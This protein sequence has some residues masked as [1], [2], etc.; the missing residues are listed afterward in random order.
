MTAPAQSPP[1]A[2]SQSPGW[3]E[4][5]AGRLVSCLASG[6]DPDETVRQILR[7]IRDETGLP[8]GDVAATRTGARPEEVPAE[9]QAQPRSDAAL[10]E[11]IIRDTTERAQAEAALRLSQE[12]LRRA[13]TLAHIGNWEWTLPTGELHWEE[14][15]HRIFGLAPDVKPSVETFLAAVHPEDRAFVEQSIQAALRGRPYDLDM[16]ILRPDGVERVVHAFA[17]VQRDADGQPVRMFGTVQDITDRRRAEEEG[18]KLQAE[19]FQAQKME[20]IGTL[21]GGI[22]HDFNNLL[23]GIMS[24][25]SLLELDLGEGSGFHQDLEEIKAQVKRGA[26]LTRQ[27][28]GFARGGR[29]DATPQDLNGILERM[30]GMFGR[31]RK[32]LTIRVECSPGI[33]A[34]MADPTQIE[35]TLLNLFLN[36]GQ[37][38]PDGGDLR[39]RTECVVLPAAETRA[40]GTEPGRF[41]KLSV[42]DT[43]VGMDAD[44]RA[45]I[46]DP[47]FT[48]R[49]PGRGTGLGLASVYGILRDHKGFVTVDS[50]PGQGSTFAVFLPA[51]DSPAV[52]PPTVSVAP[53]R[54]GETILVVD[55]EEQIVRTSSRLLQALGHHVLTA[56]SGR[57]ALEVFKQNQ[58]VVAL[59]ILDMIMPGLSGRQTM[60]AMREL[61]PDVKVLLSSGYHVDGQAAEIL[62][63]G[64]Q[65]FLAKPFDLATLS[66]KLRE[67]L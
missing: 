61:A 40:Y 15:N 60:A 46:F 55:D 38:M 64:C 49:Q 33:P 31:T 16:R 19:L 39:L 47:F 1:E 42:T 11:S 22:A 24:G 56:R 59:V 7:A 63:R 23:G 30:A 2:G 54:G 53:R 29:C 62:A 50:A 26:D 27:L 12:R 32:D 44:T 17:E 20:S 34:V 66:E 28:L 37:A 35:Q 65:G 21:A 52:E 5:L 57:E 18:R 36:A 51:T 43:G 13:Q 14:E 3:R 9:A 67:I 25:L 6:S 48:T 58:Q 41:V 8:V 4:R 10:R 45:R